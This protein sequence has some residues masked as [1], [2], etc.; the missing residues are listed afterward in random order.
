MQIQK[1]RDKKNKTKMSKNKI[2][3]Y[4]VERMKEPTMKAGLKKIEQIAMKVVY[5]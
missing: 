5:D 3:V 2:F 1:N 4:G